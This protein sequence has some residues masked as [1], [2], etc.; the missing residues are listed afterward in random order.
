MPQMRTYN[1]WP[2]RDAIFKNHENYLKQRASVKRLSPNN[3]LHKTESMFFSPMRQSSFY[4]DMDI[5]QLVHD[6][7]A[8][9]VE[10]NR[11]KERSMSSLKATYTK[12]RQ[13][14]QTMQSPL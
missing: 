5:T 8:V 10:R 11:E 2:S 3:A 4:K 7:I 9:A 14:L 12:S 1:N 6:P 13:M